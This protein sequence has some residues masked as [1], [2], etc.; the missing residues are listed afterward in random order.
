MMLR[1]VTVSSNDEV[2]EGL[3]V[4]RFRSDEIARI[5]QP[6]QFVNVRV[7][8]SYLPLLRRPFSISRIEGST[9]E[10][11]FNIVGI[12]TKMLSVLR[13]GER[14]DILGPLGVPFDVRETFETALIVGGGVGVAPFPLLTEVLQREEKNIVSF[15]GARSAYQLYREHLKNSHFATDD[16]SAGFK[17]N[18]V[19]LLEQ[20]LESHHPA[21]PKIF[22]CGPTPMLK[23]LSHLAQRHRI[24]CEV[25]L[26]GDM[27]CGIGLCQGCPVER[28]NGP[29]KYALVCSEGPA[30]HSQDIVL[31]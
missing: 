13:P 15:I 2:G 30:F 17:G 4:L 29:K 27:A 22:G 1:I 20:Y 11:L 16:G 7:T 12:G 5:A 28:V 26:E 8:D 14:I 24:L 25:S 31:N 18:V 6:G 21:Q 10:L 3:F 9:I 19:H 23:S